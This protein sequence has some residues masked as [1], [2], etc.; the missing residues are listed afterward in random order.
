MTR[1]EVIARISMR[2]G[3]VR[4]LDTL[5]SGELDATVERLE[6]ESFLPW[7][8]LSENNITK[9]EAGE[10]RVPIPRGFLAEYE[11]GSLSVKVDG[12]WVPL[13]KMHHD[14]ARVMFAGA[15]QGLPTRY[16]LTNKYFRLYPTPDSSDYD[17]ELL[18]YRRSETIV[19]TTNPWFVEASAWVIYETAASMLLSRKDKKYMEM[20]KLAAEQ[21]TK[22]YARHIQ[23]EEANLDT[24]LGGDD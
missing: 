4:G 23:R 5:I 21:R 3:N 15:A 9:T 7:F 10:E 6:N 19:N 11:P 12:V 2:L 8:L 17:L 14:D 18:L 22:I 13:K 1:E 24:Y 20:E 16:S